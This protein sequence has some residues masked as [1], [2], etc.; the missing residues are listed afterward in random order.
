MRKLKVRG[1]FLKLLASSD[2][3]IRWLK[4]LQSIPTAFEGDYTQF[5]ITG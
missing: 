3:T 1:N 5:N 2:S 4:I